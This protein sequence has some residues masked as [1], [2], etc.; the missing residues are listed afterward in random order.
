MSGAAFRPVD[1]GPYLRWWCERFG[2]ASDAFAGLACYQRGK[3]SV[4][5]ARCD[6]ALA[7][8]EPVDGVG[9]PFVRVGRAD[10]KATNAAAVRFGHLATRQFVELAAED[11]AAVMRGETLQLRVGDSRVVAA[12]GGHA[13]VRFRGLG[14]GCAR[15]VDGE[16]RSEIPRGRQLDCA[17]LPE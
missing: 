14:V 5:I 11:L 12:T 3:S 13:I 7:G 6:L 8:L 17:D 4:W 10:W 15:L 16:L 1:A 2:A 9:I